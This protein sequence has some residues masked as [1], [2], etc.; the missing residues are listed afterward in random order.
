MASLVT[1]I[2]QYY[3][4]TEFLDGAVV[5][6]NKTT[7]RREHK[8]GAGGYGTVWREREE[9]TGRLRAVKILSKIQL[10]VRELEAL[11]Q[12]Q[13]VSPLMVKVVC[14]ADG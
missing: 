12:L 4:N 1:R 5:H 8:L 9:R 14:K 3:L 11:I 13:D 10:N 6:G 7:W 2:N